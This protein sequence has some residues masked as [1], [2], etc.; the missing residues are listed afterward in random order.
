MGASRRVVVLLLSF[1]NPSPKPWAGERL[2]SEWRAMGARLEQVTTSCKVTL[3][4]R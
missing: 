1:L 3:C 2:E 4:L